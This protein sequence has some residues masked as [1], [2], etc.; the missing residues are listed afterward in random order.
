[1]IDL[2]EKTAK[3][4]QVSFEYEYYHY[5]KSSKVSRNNVDDKAVE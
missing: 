3:N 5:S 4:Y 2:F 1:M